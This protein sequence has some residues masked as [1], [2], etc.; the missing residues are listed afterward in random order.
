MAR[1]MK[2]HELASPVDISDMPIDRGDSLRWT[3]VTIAVATIALLFAN[4][5]TLAAW[6]DE[7]A[8]TPAQQRLASVA[9]GWSDAMASIGIT[10][11]RRK[12]HETWKKLQAVRFGEEAPAGSQ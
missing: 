9:T 3:A 5:G 8:P 2:D 11:P 4:A 6:V 7:M 10:T 12:L 1:E